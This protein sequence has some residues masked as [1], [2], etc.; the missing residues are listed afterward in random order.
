MSGYASKILEIGGAKRIRAALKEQGKR[1]VFTNGCFDILHP[2]HTRYLEQARALGDHLMVAVNSDRSVRAIKG[3][4]RPILN[5]KSRAEVL[6]ALAFVDTVII[7]DE[8]TPLKVINEL[9]PDILVKGRDW[10]EDRIIGSE[11]VKK[12]GGR[13][14]RIPF[15]EGFSTSLIIQAVV[16][17]YCRNA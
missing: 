11:T 17:R 14:E 15:A 16:E 13:V 2:G 5:E 4:N 6:A 9:V 10:A 7:F 1:V 12:A 3:P 8:E